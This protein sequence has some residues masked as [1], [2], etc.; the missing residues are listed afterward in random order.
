MRPINILYSIHICTE[1]E[2]EGEGEYII[3]IHFPYQDVTQ[4]SHH[5]SEMY[6]LV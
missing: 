3:L 6:G 4:Y 2:N 1:V 5:S